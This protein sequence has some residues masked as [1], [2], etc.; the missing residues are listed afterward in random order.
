MNQDFTEKLAFYN[1]SQYLGYDNSPVM[2]MVYFGVTLPVKNLTDYMEGLYDIIVNQYEAN[3]SYLTI[4]VGLWLYG[5]DQ[6]VA[7]G[8]YDE[9]IQIMLNG[10]KNISHP[11]Y[12]RIGYEFNGICT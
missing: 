1:Y 8:Q 12:M 5:F 11:V 3:G 4:Q 6:E 9:Q 2:F 10:F 7:D